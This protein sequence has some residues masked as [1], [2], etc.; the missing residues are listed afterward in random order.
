ME[1]VPRVRLTRRDWVF[2]AVCS[3]VALVSLLIISRFFSSTFPEASIEFRR[4]HVAPGR[5]SACSST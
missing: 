4:R 2:I 5:G 1:A 3:A